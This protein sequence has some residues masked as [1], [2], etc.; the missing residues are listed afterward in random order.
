MSRPAALLV[1]VWLA[2]PTAAHAGEPASRLA[3]KLRLMGNMGIASAI[4]EMGGTFTYAPAP[5]L[6]IELGA[7]LGFSGFQLA[8]LPKISAGSSHHRLTLG[9]GPS[10]GIGTNRS[11]S[12]TCVSYWL[13]AEAGYEYRSASGFA[14]LVALG[15]GKGLAGTMPG[16]PVTGLD[17][18]DA[19]TPLSASQRSAFPQGRIAFG[20][21]F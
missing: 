20:R 4:G 13:N 9:I 2:A 11:P 7:G 6:Q 8:L 17:T 12:V 15:I 21:W 5:E 16:S 18:A 14:F 10:V 1:L 3:A 19:V